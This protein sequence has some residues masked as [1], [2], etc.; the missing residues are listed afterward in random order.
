M[1][2]IKEGRAHI[3]VFEGVFYNPM[4][5]FSRTFGVSSLAAF[6]RFRGKNLIVADAMAATGIRGI[7]YFLES[8]AVDKVIFN[9]KM[10]GAY[11]NIKHNVML[12]KI[13]NYEVYNYD[14]NLFNELVCRNKVDAIDIDPFGSP[15]PYID[16]LVRA[17]KHKG[18]VIISA[19]D[20]TALCGI[21]PSAAFR[22]YF[23]YVYKNDFCHEVAL[24]ILIK[25]LVVAGGRNNRCIYPLV[26]MFSEQYARV[27]AYVLSA[28]RIPRENIGYICED[29][30]GF[31]VVQTPNKLKSSRFMGPLWVGPLHETHF[32]NYLEDAIS[33]LELDYTDVKRLKKLLEIMK[34]EVSLPP[35]SYK[36]SSLVSKLKVPQPKINKMIELLESVGYLA[37]RSHM[38]RDLLKTN[39]PI[40][41]IEDLLRSEDLK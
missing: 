22:K 26:S 13:S 15:S 1:R 28:K 41:V 12:N 37:G 14:T 35:Y 11:E 31:K 9:D 40:Q 20:L 29:S 23:S 17:V 3:K 6:S 39:A 32:L 27:Y 7:R 8:G 5:A 24:R 10:S 36:L 19:T 4:A 38:G 30:S 25:E 33:T 16:S 2:V 18:M 21:Y 34:K